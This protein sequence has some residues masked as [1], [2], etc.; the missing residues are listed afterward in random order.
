MKQVF[1][2]IQDEKGAGIYFSNISNDLLTELLDYDRHPTPEWDTKLY[3][4]APHLFQK[5]N[6]FDHESY[7]TVFQRPKISFLV[8]QVISNSAHGST[9]MHCL[10]SLIKMVSKFI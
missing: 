4:S 2:R 9:M 6:E 3:N 7:R 1:I 8:S 10:K 5:K